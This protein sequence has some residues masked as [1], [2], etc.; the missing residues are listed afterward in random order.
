M[1]SIFIDRKD[2]RFNELLNGAIEKFG[3]KLNRDEVKTFCILEGVRMRLIAYGDDAVILDE[4]D[5]D[6]ITAF[7]DGG[8]YSITLRYGTLFICL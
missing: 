6:N 5:P 1:I 7:I 3:M 4:V 8:D 2:D